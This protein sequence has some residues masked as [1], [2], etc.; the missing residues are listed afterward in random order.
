MSRPGRWRAQLGSLRTSGTESSSDQDPPLRTTENAGY[1]GP[2]SRLLGN[3]VRSPIGVW[4][5][6]STP[7]RL[8]SGFK[9]LSD[10]LPE[11]AA[12]SPASHLPLER[13][14]RVLLHRL[15]GPGSTEQHPTGE[16]N[17]HNGGD[18][19]QLGNE[20]DCRHDEDH[21][22]NGEEQQSDTDE[23]DTHDGQFS[24]QRREIRSVHEIERPTGLATPAETTA[25]P[26]STHHPTMTFRVHHRFR[27]H[28]QSQPG[29]HASAVDARQLNRCLNDRCGRWSR[30]GRALDPPTIGASD[31]VRSPQF[32]GMRHGPAMAVGAIEARKSA[33]E[34]AVRRRFA[35]GLGRDAQR[36]DVG[37]VGADS[38][39]MEV[40]W[41]GLIR[42][43]SLSSSGCRYG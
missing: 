28:S 38:S 15:D 22:A 41:R 13:V 5:H 24:G 10:R 36:L 25:N 20:D 7:G 27:P 1:R 8:A 34:R 18:E 33:S 39:Y 12:G 37:R 21:R 19:E 16:A 30:G 23:D 32:R 14:T 43:I 2:S 40:V 35:D 9:L 4:R 17:S 42:T 31:V 6:R 26:A 11:L 29:Q 3:R